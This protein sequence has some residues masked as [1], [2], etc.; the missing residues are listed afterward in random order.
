MVIGNFLVK[1]KTLHTDTGMRL[2]KF[3]RKLVSYLFSSGFISGVRKSADG[4]L[5]CGCLVE[6]RDVNCSAHGLPAVLS[7]RFLA[8]ILRLARCGQWRLKSNLNLGRMITRE[9]SGAAL[10]GPQQRTRVLEPA[11]RWGRRRRAYLAAKRWSSNIQS[12]WP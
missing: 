8:D 4:S 2:V 3:F 7:P 1:S 5:Q 6:I 9:R 12:R 11:T 10:Q